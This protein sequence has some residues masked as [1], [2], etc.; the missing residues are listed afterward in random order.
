MTGALHIPNRSGHNTIEWDT[1]QANGNG[2]LDPE[3]AAQEFNR[4]VEGGHLGFG[5]TPKGE[6]TQL[7][8]FDPVQTP[9]EFE[10]VT[11]IPPMAGG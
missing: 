9:R 10:K 1:E 6:H 5:T 11:V 2:P 8:K 7:K 3:Y 4:L